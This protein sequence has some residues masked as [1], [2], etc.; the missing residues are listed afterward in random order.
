MAS[1]SFMRQFNEPPYGLLLSDKK[2]VVATAERSQA[3]AL[4]IQPGWKLSDVSFK[5][6]GVHLLT[7]S[8]VLFLIY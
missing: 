4:K 5:G 6:P 1:V 3:K 2:V 7:F 8:Q